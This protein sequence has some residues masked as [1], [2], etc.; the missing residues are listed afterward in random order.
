MKQK[1]GRRLHGGK[2]KDLSGAEGQSEF[3]KFSKF[4]EGNSSATVTQTLFRIGNVLVG[5]DSD[6]D[7][8]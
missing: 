6:L 8:L 5:E 7:T 1:S 4:G 2:R 3:N